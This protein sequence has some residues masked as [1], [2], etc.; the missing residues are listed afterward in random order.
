M[1][2]IA[3]EVIKKFQRGKKDTGSSEVQIALLTKRIGD[4]TDHLKVNRK[5]E[6]SRYGLLMM[7]SKRRRL[8]KYFKRVNL[9][10]YMSLIQELGIRD[11]R[12]Q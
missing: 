6:H 7:V 5:D 4:L 8:L 11:Q 3:S 2:L 12:D 10:R 1:A 9:D